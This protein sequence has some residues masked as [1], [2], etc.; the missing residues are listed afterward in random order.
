MKDSAVARCLEERAKRLTLGPWLQSKR[1]FPPF[2]ESPDLRPAF[3]I[4]FPMR[5]PTLGASR[6]RSMASAAAKRTTYSIYSIEVNII[7]KALL[8]HSGKART[9]RS[10]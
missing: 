10:S 7:E 5:S 2:E 3:A 4:L 8:S 6:A 9:R 1:P